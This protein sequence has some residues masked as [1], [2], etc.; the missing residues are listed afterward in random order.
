M[1]TEK[2]RAIRGTFDWITDRQPAVVFD[3]VPELDDLRRSP[4][5]CRTRRVSACTARRTTHDG[6]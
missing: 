3:V 2:D 1:K 6:A 5:T 4:H